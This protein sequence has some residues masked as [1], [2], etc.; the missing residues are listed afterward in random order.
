MIEKSLKHTMAKRKQTPPP[1]ETPPKKRLN[2]VLAPTTPDMKEKA[3]TLDERF[4]EFS[5]RCDEI[6]ERDDPDST[7]QL[8]QLTVEMGFVGF[9]ETEEEKAAFAAASEWSDTDSDDIGMSM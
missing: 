4:A 2:P 5:R 8:L 6:I 3:R 7:E 9:P 1:A